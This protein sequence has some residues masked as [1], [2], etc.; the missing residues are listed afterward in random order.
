MSI[1]KIKGCPRCSGDLF[2]QSEWGIWTEHCLQCGYEKEL[3]L[4]ARELE[5]A[6]NREA[7][8]Q[9]EFEKE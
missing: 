9:H 5:R 4:S 7:E 1:W 3:S 8:R 6:R 2:L